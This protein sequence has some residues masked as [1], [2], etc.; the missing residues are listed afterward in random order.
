MPLHFISCRATSIVALVLS[1][2][3]F[4]PAQELSSPA[5]P[6]KKYLTVD[7]HLKLSQSA[8]AN[9]DPRGYRMLLDET[10]APRFVSSITGAP[11]DENWDYRFGFPAVQ[12]G[13]VAAITVTASGAVYFGGDFTGLIGGVDSANY[14]ARYDPGTRRWSRLS[15]GVDGLVV[16]LAADGD[17]LYVGGFFTHA[18]GNGAQYIAHWSPSSGTWASLGTGVSGGASPFVY[19]L[20]VNGGYLY[21]GGQFT[22]AGGV[23]V[24]NLARWSLSNSTWS[25]VGGGVTGISAQVKALE[26][27]SSGG[28]Y[29]GGIFTG[30]GAVS[31][32]NIAHW[33]GSTWTPVGRGVNNQVFAIARG[34]DGTLYIGGTFTSATDSDGTVWPVSSIAAFLFSHRWSDMQGG[35]HSPGLAFVGA[36]SYVNGF[37]YVGGSFDTSG[38]GVVTHHVAKYDHG[39]WHNLGSGTDAPTGYGVLALASSGSRLFVGGDFSHPGPFLARGVSLWNDSTGSWESLGWG[40]QNFGIVAAEVD[41]ILVDPFDPHNIYVGGIFDHVGGISGVANIARFNFDAQ[42]WYP[43]GQGVRSAG[44]IAAVHALAFYSGDIYV[45]GLFDTAGTTTVHNLAR[46]NRILGRW[47]DPGGNPDGTVLA[48]QI[49]ASQLYVGGSFTM[50]GGLQSEGIA[51]SDGTAWS[52]V[53]GGAVGAVYSLATESSVSNAPL[54]VGGAMSGV[55]TAADSTIAVSNIARWDGNAWSTLGPPPAPSGPVGTVHAILVF[56]GTVYA[57][58]DFTLVS[59]PGSGFVTTPANRLARFD[60][61]SWSEVGGGIDPSASFGIVVNSLAL[62]PGGGLC[63]AGSFSVAGSTA[64]NNIAEYVGFNTWNTLG[65]GIQP[66]YAEPSAVKVLAPAFTD[67]YVGGAFARAGGGLALCFSRWGQP[68]PVFSWTYHNIPDTV[69]LRCISVSQYPTV[70][71]GGSNGTIYESTNGGTS[72]SNQATGTSADIKTIYSF[73]LRTEIAGGTNGTMLRSTDGGATW[74]PVPFSSAASI[75]AI[76]FAPDGLHGVAVL[77][78]ETPL[79]S[80]SDIILTTDGGKTWADNSLPLHP[81]LYHV[82]AVGESTFVAVG[83]V[84]R[85]YKSTDRGISWTAQPGPTL[86][87]LNVVVFANDQVGFAAG[88]FGTILRTTDGGS[89]WAQVLS[90]TNANLYDGGISGNEVFFC[91]AGGIIITSSDGGLTFALDMIVPDGFGIFGMSITGTSGPGTSK[92]AASA[93]AFAV[94]DHGTVITKQLGSTGVQDAQ[95]NVPTSFGLYQN[96]PNPFNPTTTIQYHIGGVV[97][98]T[99]VRLVVYDILGREVATLVN[100]VERPGRYTVHFDGS[101]LASGVYFYRLVAGSFSKTKNMILLK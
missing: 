77:A 25:D 61:V 5:T 46:W 32:G 41:A 95:S 76:T 12:S 63:V 28:V 6:I 93:T 26:A 78:A 100:E 89:T 97:A 99:N 3:S 39:V 75:N 50:I 85:I 40:V 66:L 47:E 94:G 31:A 84:G 15:T 55:K 96:Y 20:S 8:G 83:A 35:V 21:V 65:S 74:V 33:D 22:N 80:F 30:A 52:P 86:A 64:A 59:Q 58:G 45:G 4:L 43:L 14:I 67:L 70:F 38:S 69:L 1:A 18:G 48:M 81:D 71:V 13:N 72:W 87:S 24:N 17:E 9:I 56:G 57:G 91:G 79:S 68:L 98:S 16:A 42:T 90:G 54:Y 27:D 88:N 36:L 62:L 34:T 19:A 92:A 11:G 23:S 82:T 10:G 49:Y 60:G 2:W 7:G 101:S 29:V 37:L 44:G 51:R 73:P 53:A